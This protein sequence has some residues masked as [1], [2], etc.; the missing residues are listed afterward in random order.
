MSE[1]VPVTSVDKV[2]DEIDGLVLAIFEGMRTCHE[3]VGTS[4]EQSA[5]DNIAV[6]YNATVDSIQKLVGIDRSEADQ[7]KHLAELSIKYDLSKSRVLQL[8]STLIEIQRSVHEQLQNAAN[9]V[10]I[11]AENVL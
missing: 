2:H 1:L 8:E 10:H 6:K 9:G 3:N 5:A 11:C 4:V 7:L